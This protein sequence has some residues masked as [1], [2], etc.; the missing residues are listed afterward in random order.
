MVFDGSFIKTKI[1][2]LNQDEILFRMSVGESK[3]LTDEKGLR[4]YNL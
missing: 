2:E 4:I 1:K 3:T